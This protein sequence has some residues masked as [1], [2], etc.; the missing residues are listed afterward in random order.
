MIVRAAAAADAAAIGALIGELGYPTVGADVPGRL[1]TLV[2]SGRAVALVAE[3]DGTVVGLVT[4]H[5]LATLHHPEP[6][7]WLTTLVVSEAARGLGA[8]RQLVRAA[9]EWARAQGAVRISVTS[10]IQ[11]ADAHEFYRRIGYAQT[12]LRFGKAL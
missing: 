10:G 1:A 4:A 9:E 12:G 2:A 7:A 5:M 11:R 8:G 3:S 6:V